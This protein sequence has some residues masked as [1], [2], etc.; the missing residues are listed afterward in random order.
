MGNKRIKLVKES[1]GCIGVRTIKT[2]C[3]K[4]VWL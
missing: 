1:G 2:I 4:A 3:G